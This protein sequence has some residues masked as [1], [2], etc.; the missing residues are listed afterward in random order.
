MH[1]FRAH[2]L[3]ASV[4]GSVENVLS[5]MPRQSTSGPCRSLGPLAGE[6]VYSP[7][8]WTQEI[9][10]ASTTGHG[11]VP[12]LV[13]AFGPSSLLTSSIDVPQLPTTKTFGLGDKR[14]DGV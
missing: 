13:R 2:S 10:P 3:D 5:A 1:T 9:S 11:C 7:L 12:F 8:G 6:R 4:S 14:R